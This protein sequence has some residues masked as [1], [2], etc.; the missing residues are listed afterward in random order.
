VIYGP[1]LFKFVTYKITST[2][3]RSELNDNIVTLCY[4]IN[5]HNNITNCCIVGYISLYVSV[6][7]ISTFDDCSPSLYIVSSFVKLWKCC[8]GFVF[9]YPAVVHR[10]VRW[11][12][13]F[14]FDKHVEVLYM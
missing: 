14:P 8:S 12:H 2:S 10:N 5:N 7:I 4:Y 13:F 3:S 6:N 1:F 11:V 9:V